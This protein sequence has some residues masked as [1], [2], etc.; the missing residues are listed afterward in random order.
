MFEQELNTFI[1]NLKIAG[2]ILSGQLTGVSEPELTGDAIF[3]T[4]NP[5]TD[6]VEEQKYFFWKVDDTINYKPLVVIS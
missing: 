4:I 6:K 1:N 2:T 5:A 3:K